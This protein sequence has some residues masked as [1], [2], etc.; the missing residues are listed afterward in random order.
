MLNAE[1]IFQKIIMKKLIFTRNF[2][3]ALYFLPTFIYNLPKNPIKIYSPIFSNFFDVFL[4]QRWDFFAPPPQANNKLYFS[5]FDN[6][7]NKIGTFEVLSP[8]VD[9]KKQTL[10]LNTKAE[11]LDY[12]INGQINEILFSIVDKSNELKYKLK[13]NEESENFRLARLEVLKNLNDSKPFKTLINF[14]KIVKYQNIEKQV[15]VKYLKI[16]I[17]EEK[18]NKFVDRYENKREERLLIETDFLSYE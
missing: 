17:M 1:A 13:E 12:I 14:S 15:D 16:I 4:Q 10:P 7:F 8:I 9:M 5:Y 18:I 6:N 2:L 11:T 3:L